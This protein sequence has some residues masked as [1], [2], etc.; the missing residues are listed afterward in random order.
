MLVAAL[1]GAWEGACRAGVDEVDGA[2]VSACWVCVE[3]PEEPE[4]DPEPE[5]EL[6]LDPEPDVR[7]FAEVEGLVAAC[8]CDV[9]VEVFGVVADLPG[10]AWA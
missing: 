8:A 3:V 7:L 1:V 6:E 2:C 5:L 9:D 10:A 4:A